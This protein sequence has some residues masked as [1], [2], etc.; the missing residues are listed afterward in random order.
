MTT[1]SAKLP[2]L[3][4]SEQ[5][6]AN[7]ILQAARALV[8][9]LLAFN[10]AQSERRKNRKEY[11]KTAEMLSHKADTYQHSSPAYAEELRCYAV[12]MLNRARSFQ[13]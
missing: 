4:T 3:M 10:G 5:G 7:N 8:A 1:L 12:D 2:N 11:L 13:A 6:Y 9:A